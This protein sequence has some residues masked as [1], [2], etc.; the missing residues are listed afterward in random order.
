WPRWLLP[1]QTIVQNLERDAVGI[2]RLTYGNG[3]EADYQRSKEGSLARIVYRDPRQPASREQHGGALAALLGVR[4]ALAASA[5]AL[6][7]ALELPPDPK[8]LLDHRYLWDTQGNLLY[9]R[10]KDTASGYAYDARD[11]LIVAAA[12]P[13]ASFARYHYDDNGNRLLA[14]EAIDQSDIRGN[15][16]K[17]GYAP[18]ADRWRSEASSGGVADVH[19]D[20][21]GLPERIGKRSLM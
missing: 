8:A 11:R 18:D 2:K 6:P 17:T 13:H 3:I 14:Q 21:T 15:T 5:T 16:V 7:G 20:A 9:T 10:D 4:P 1:R 19:Y 12:G